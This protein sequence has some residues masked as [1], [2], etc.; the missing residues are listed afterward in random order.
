MFQ[1]L[2]I[3]GHAVDIAEKKNSFYHLFSFLHV[4]VLLISSSAVQL[5]SGN[6]NN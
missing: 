6:V 2:S 1:Q 3:F 5:P 4:L